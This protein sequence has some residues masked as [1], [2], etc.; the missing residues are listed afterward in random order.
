[1][2][3]FDGAIQ[4]DDSEIPVILAVEEDRIRLS[5]SGTEI[6]EWQV[7]EYEITPGDRGTYL[8][9][10]DGDTVTFRPFRPEAFARAVGITTASASP[11]PAQ[12]TAGPTMADDDHHPE[13]PPPRPLTRALFLTLAGITALL[14]VWALLLLFTGG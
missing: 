13:A 9:S 12:S 5:S 8:I 3:L 2:P 14:G 7:G 4:L 6:G 11:T 1:M 10:A